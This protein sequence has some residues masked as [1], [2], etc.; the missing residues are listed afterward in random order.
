MKRKQKRKKRKKQRKTFKKKKKNPR[1]SNSSSS[2]SSGSSGV[3]SRASGGEPPRP[4]PRARHRALLVLAPLPRDALVE[5]VVRVW[6]REQRLHRDEHGP[7]LQRRGPLVLEDVEAD[8]SEL[9]DVGVVDLGEEPDLFFVERGRG[10]RECEREERERRGTERERERDSEK[11][12][13]GEERRVAAAA[14]TARKGTHLRFLFPPVSSR[15]SAHLWCRHWVVLGKEELELEDAAWFVY[16]RGEKERDREREE[17][18]EQSFFLLLLFS[19][20]ARHRRQ[21]SRKRKNHTFVRR[22]RRP[23]DLHLE[24]A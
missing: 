3:S 2:W 13:G 6:R 11:K 23:V 20:F 12:R 17:E 16:T 10:E 21:L 22:V 5:R 19:S 24:I 18:V 14:T 4:V 15:L 7:D 1:L 8:A 9:V